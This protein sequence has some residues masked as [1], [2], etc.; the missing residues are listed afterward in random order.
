MT[1]FRFL[2][3]ALVSALSFSFSPGNN[4]FSQKIYTP[5]KMGYNLVW[6]DNF[7]GSEL[8][9][10]KWE[11]RGIG[12][13]RLG[14][15]SE[16]AVKVEDG[17]LKLFA[18]QKGDSIL[19]GAVGTQ[20]HFNPRYGY[21]ECRAQLQESDGVWAAFWMQ[22]ALI[23]QG[24]DPA[25]YGT[26]IDIFEFFKGVGKDTIQHALHW[27]YGPDMKS[28][29]PMNSYL[30]GLS[31]GFHTFAMEWTPEKYVFYIDGQKFHTQMQG[32]SHI[33]EYVILSMELPDS[34]EQLSNTVF[35]DVFIIDYV[36]VYQK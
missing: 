4:I 25:K 35:P 27:A 13:R 19:S 18:L 28:I 16:E 11:V 20:K 29:G 8:D 24:S 36:R 9:T 12:P 17:F 3:L 31:T 14:Y 32:I 23:S 22:S 26:E 10:T 6:E 1:I 2:S 7:D 33:N 15:I 21:F 5:E 30:E 34:I